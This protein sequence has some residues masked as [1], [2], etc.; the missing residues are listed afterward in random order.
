MEKT[1]NL[2]NLEV[3]FLSYAD[4]GKIHDKKNV[5]PYFLREVNCIH[6]RDFLEKNDFLRLATIA[7][8][9]VY[10]PYRELQ[11]LLKQKGAK[12]GNTKEK[13]A[14]NAKLYLTPEEIEAHF[15]YCCYIPTEKAR[16]YI[17]KNVDYYHIDLQLDLLKKYQKERYD[18]Y[19]QIDIY[20][21]VHIYN[22]NDSIIITECG[23]N[24]LLSRYNAC[25]IRVDI[26]LFFDDLYFNT[27]YLVDDFYYFKNE[28]MLVFV[29][30]EIENKQYFCSFYNY[31][32]YELIEDV[33]FSES[34]WNYIS[35][36]DFDFLTQV[37]SNVKPIYEDR[38]DYINYRKK[39]E[40]LIKEQK[41][42]YNQDG[43]KNY[44]FYI[45][46]PIA[47]IIITQWLSNRI[48]VEII[49]SEFIV[50]NYEN[51]KI[52]VPNT[53]TK[54]EYLILWM[55]HERKI[56]PPALNGIPLSC[57]CGFGVQKHSKY[58][59]NYDETQRRLNDILEEN[60]V[61]MLDFFYQTYPIK[62]LVFFDYYKS[63]GNNGSWDYRYMCDNIKEY[64]NIY[65]DIIL[66]L[67]ENG[68]LPHRWINEFSLYLLVKSYF[69]D[70]IFQYRTEWLGLQ[71]IDIFIPSRKIG[72]EYQ[73][74]QHYAAI[75]FFGGEEGL[76][77]VRE[78]DKNKMKKC[79]NNQILL[80]YWEYKVEISEINLKKLLKTVNI[81]I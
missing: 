23:D 36:N 54:Y 47:K 76:E 20:D 39:V 31:S 22:N 15:G 19:S 65:H 75:D 66:E 56:M 62:V 32:S 35:R 13:V 81:M 77:N 11:K 80:L 10:Y 60:K 5:Y 28:K 12:I 52:S 45:L 51:Y 40:S 3:A 63:Y 59:E 48:K 64:E 71:S 73:G 41:G 33:E 29:T 50:D 70:A 67:K 68:I 53:E 14:E 21:E 69:E 79:Q 1:V 30:C 38:T 16:P 25:E 57:F 42:I 37:S 24:I 17:N 43:S 55:F 49:P 4:M 8:S 6:I 46:D 78:R 18:Y 72:I 74:I 27:F 44:Y 61:D 58:Y 2:I 26:R 9:I 34:P 7:E